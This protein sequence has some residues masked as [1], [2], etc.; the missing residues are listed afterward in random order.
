MRQGR[1]A[2]RA[3]FFHNLF[4][5]KKNLRKEK[6]SIDKWFQIGYNLVARKLQILFHVFLN[7]PGVFL[8]TAFSCAGSPRVRCKFPFKQ[9]ALSSLRQ[10]FLF[11]P[12]PWARGL[13]QNRGKVGWGRKKSDKQRNIRAKS[14]LSA[15]ALSVCILFST[16]CGKSLCG[17]HFVFPP[18]I[19]YY[20]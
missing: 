17:A 8:L 5:N 14:Y 1:P 16:S 11:C 18:K 19:W 7:R 9:K 4:P 15:F 10:G 2:F 13:Q 20:R 6:K 3:A 12:G